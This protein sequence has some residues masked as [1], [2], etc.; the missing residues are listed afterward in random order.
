MI[1]RPPRS[2]LFPYT[3]LF[4]SVDVA[5]LV[6][7]VDRD[8]DRAAL[9][10]DGPRHGL[11]DPPVGVGAEL[12]AAAVVELLDRPGEAEAAFLDQVG[13]GEPP[14]EVAAGGPGRQAGD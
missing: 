13:K 3:T 14:P 9:V 5:D 7:H 11:A 4:R 12:E 6:D 1:R 2:T 10:G 8:A